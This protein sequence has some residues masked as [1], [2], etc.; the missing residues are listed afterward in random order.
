MRASAAV[1]A[2]HDVGVRCLSVLLA[3]GFRSDCSE[4]HEACRQRIAAG[5]AS[6]AHHIHNGLTVVIFP[7]AI[8]SPALL[9]WGLRDVRR[10]RALAIYSLV[11]AILTAV[12]LALYLTGAVEDWNGAV[13][14]G[15]ITLPLLWVAVLGGRLLRNSATAP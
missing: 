4:V 7:L 3:G 14:R 10:E 6:L 12:L 1:F 5:D 2:Y 15:F 11:T 9:G 13:Q 8:I